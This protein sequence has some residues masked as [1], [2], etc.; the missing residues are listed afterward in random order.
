M[1]DPAA[2]PG[3][4][5]G[6]IVAEAVAC[7]RG[8]RLVFA[9][10]SCRLAAGGALLLTGPNGSGKSSLLRLLATLLPPEA[11]RLLWGG[12]AIAGDPAPYRASLHYVGHLDAIKPALT[13]RETLT[14]WAGLRELRVDPARVAAALSALGLDRVAD[15][16][17]RWLSAGQRKRLALAR[18]VA[19][20]A[21]VWLL[22]EPTAG[23]DRDGEERLVRLIGAHRDAGG[24]VALATHQALP[25]PGAQALALGDFAPTAAARAVDF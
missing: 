11:G 19:A 8:E 5:G 4:N 20:P 7:R 9:G 21:P 12:V 24:R 14:F 1:A 17:C 22:D 10:L 2:E 23:L 18:L 3:E 13:P 16:P 15:W 6:D 25:V